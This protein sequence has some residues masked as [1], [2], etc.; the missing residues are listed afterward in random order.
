MCNKNGVSAI[1]KTPRFSMVAGTR[2]DTEPQKTYEFSFL[3]TNMCKKEYTN[4]YK[5]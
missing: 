3:L 5:E 4:L 2:F 1:A